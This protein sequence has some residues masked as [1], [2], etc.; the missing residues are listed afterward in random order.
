MN[1][2]DI[3]AIEI[4]IETLKRIEKDLLKNNTLFNNYRKI[5]EVHPDKL[6]NNITM[7]H[8]QNIEDSN[9]Q[10]IDQ[11][12][13]VNTNVINTIKALEKYAEAKEIEE[14]AKKY[15]NLE[16]ELNQL[17]QAGGGQ[18]KSYMKFNNFHDVEYFT[19]R[20][21]SD[22]IEKNKGQIEEDK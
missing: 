10:I 19:S 6:Y 4:D 18:Q 1:Q 5:Q 3:G 7:Q 17:T 11:Y 21:F 14:D 12:G 8:L 16:K 15:P 20:S 9:S 2:A 13:K 22:F